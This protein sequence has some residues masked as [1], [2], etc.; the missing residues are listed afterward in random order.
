MRK[1]IVTAGLVGLSASLLLAGCS[2]SAES[3]V[4]PT[5]TP[6][7]SKTTVVVAVLAQDACDD[8][9]AL[10]LV[11]SRINGDT[12]ELTKKQKKALLREIQSD[13]DLMVVSIDSAVIG[14]ELPAKALANA[15]RIQN[16]VNAANPKKGTDGIKKKSLKRINTSAERIERYCVAAGN[17]LP[18]DNINARS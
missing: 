14:G 6:A 12:G 15:E 13:T 11:R 2:S 4:T 16:N 5:V 7:P 3:E 1:S 9:F 8:Y 17:D 10:D 18:I